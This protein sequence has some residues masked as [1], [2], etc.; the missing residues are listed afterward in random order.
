MKVIKLAVVLLMTTWVSTANASLI[1]DFKI[2]D[3][4]SNV[5]VTGEIL[6]LLDDNHGQASSVRIL[7]IFSENVSLEVLAGSG[8]TFNTFDVSHG[9]LIAVILIAEYEDPQQFYSLDI[10]HDVA[11]TSNASFRRDAGVGHVIA[12]GAI[13]FA[14]REVPAP[15]TVILLSLGIAGLSFARYRK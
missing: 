6:G 8:L 1:F 13:S 14:A 7:S 15:G 5:I 2:T 10:F 4:N 9:E 3:V 11:L 12:D